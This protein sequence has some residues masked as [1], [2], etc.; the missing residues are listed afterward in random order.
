MYACMYVGGY[1]DA[2]PLQGLTDHSL[3]PVGNGLHRPRL[4]MGSSQSIVPQATD[5]W[6]IIKDAAHKNRRNGLIRM[7]WDHSTSL[8]SAAGFR[9]QSQHFNYG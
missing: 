5:G 4:D 7:I 3:A 6:C 1:I 2:V 8:S 9:Q